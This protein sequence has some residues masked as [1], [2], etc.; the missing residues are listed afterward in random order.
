MRFSFKMGAKIGS[1]I[2]KNKIKKN[3]RFAIVLMLEPTYVCNFECEGCGR[4]REYKENKTPNLTL[5][6]CLD[7][8]NQCQAPVISVCGGEPLMY[9]E[10]SEL[11]NEL[12]KLDKCVYLCTNGYMLEQKISSLPN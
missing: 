3:K 5:E 8:V 10:I 7:S 6:Q 2:Y 4:I 9:P 11:L 1:Y 12:K